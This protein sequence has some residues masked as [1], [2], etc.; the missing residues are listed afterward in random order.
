MNYSNVVLMDDRDEMLITNP[1]ETENNNSGDNDELDEDC[2]TASSVSPWSR[3]TH[4]AIFVR[5][6]TRRITHGC[7]PLTNKV[8]F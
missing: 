1:V 7:R 8:Q 6:V 3:G 2:T 5:F 4:I